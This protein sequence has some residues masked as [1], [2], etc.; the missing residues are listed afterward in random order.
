MSQV[1][2]RVS[3]FNNNNK[4]KREYKGQ[5]EEAKHMEGSCAEE[6]DAAGVLRERHW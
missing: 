6:G 5:N 4:K 2:Q 1:S 3:A